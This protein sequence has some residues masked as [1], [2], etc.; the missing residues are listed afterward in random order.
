MDV[1]SSRKNPLVAQY[2]RLCGEKEERT[3][4]RTFIGQGRKL[5]DEAIRAGS[6]ICSVLSAERLDLPDIPQYRVTED[7]LSYLS[8][9]K[10][11]PELM[12]AVRM[13]TESP[14]SAQKILLA[15]DMQDPG[16]VGTLLR[17]ANAFGFDGILLAGACADPYGPKAVRASMGAVF[18]RKIW[19]TETEAALAELKRQN[20]PLY[21]AAL[22]ENCETAGRLQFPSRLAIAIG[23]EGHGLSRTLLNG[24]DKIVRIPMEP[25]AES[26]NAAAAAAV[27]LWECYRGGNGI[28]RS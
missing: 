14:L 28:C 12:F 10:S 3:A 9:M 16:N 11:A 26:L 17:T 1:I 21:A 24:A 19:I 4:L 13:P 8:P 7:I 18:R 25:G 20:I 22:S 5:L 27:L 2:K 6:T 23:N 15:E